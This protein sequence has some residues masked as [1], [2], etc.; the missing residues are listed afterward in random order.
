[1]Q[2]VR[3]A[4][5]EDVEIVGETAMSLGSYT[6]DVQA[7]SEDRETANDAQIASVLFYAKKPLKEQDGDR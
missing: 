2:I 6:D 3:E 4:G 1:M 7:G 5:F